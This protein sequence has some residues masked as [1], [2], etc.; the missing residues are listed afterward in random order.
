LQQ[1]QANEEGD[2]VFTGVIRDS[3]GKGW[4]IRL[5]KAAGVKT[6]RWVKIR[7]EANPYDPAWKLYL[8]KRA[9]WKLGPTP[10]RT[11]PDRLPLEGARRQVRGV[12]AILA[13][14][15]TALAR[16]P[17]G[18]WRCFGGQET[19][20]NLELLHANCHRQVHARKRADQTGR[21]LQGVLR[22]A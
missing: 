12:P 3:K 22:K 4:P 17:S 14:R 11:G 21:V 10:C 8:E 5:M 16:P 19:F 2:W 6:L 20:D 7:S 1:E 18:V 9:A 13:H 15:G